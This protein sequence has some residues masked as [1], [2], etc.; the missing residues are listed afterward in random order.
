MQNVL[1]GQEQICIFVISG[2]TA[3]NLSC[4]LFLEAL[5]LQCH[6]SQPLQIAIAPML[7]QWALLHRVQQYDKWEGNLNM[8][9]FLFPECQYLSYLSICALRR[10]Q[11]AAC[12]LFCMFLYMLFLFWHGLG[13][14]HALYPVFCS[15]VFKYY[16]K[17]AFM[18]SCFW[19]ALGDVL[20][21]PVMCYFS[22]V[23][24]R[25]IFTKMVL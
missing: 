14:M 8:V 22:W 1:D 25:G 15:S 11:E 10:E 6:A 16:E 23:C 24:P 21:L 12:L 3:G 7:P 4:F 17:A 18:V 13:K 2:C 19:M 20:L 5:F 9:L